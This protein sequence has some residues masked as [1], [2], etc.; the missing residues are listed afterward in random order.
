M[1]HT[2]IHVAIVLGLLLGYGCSEDPDLETC[3][4]YCGAIKGG[5][6]NEQEGA[7]DNFCGAWNELISISGCDAIWGAMWTCYRETSQD[8]QC[9]VA[10]DWKSCGEAYCRDHEQACDEVESRYNLYK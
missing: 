7:C 3:L 10:S 2:F 1:A 4:D 8:S 9:M 6:V 5:Q